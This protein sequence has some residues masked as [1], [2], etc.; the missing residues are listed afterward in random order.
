MVWFFERGDESFRLET[1]YDNDTTEFLLVLHRP[2]GTQ[3]SERFADAM[4]F[5]QRLEAL[6]RQLGEEH[7]TQ[8]GPGFLHDGW[9]L[10]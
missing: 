10:T 8:H 2:N 7:W 4:S 6:E 9:K 1:R 5:Q 3:Q